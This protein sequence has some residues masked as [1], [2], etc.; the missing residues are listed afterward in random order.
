MVMSVRG[1]EQDKV[2]LRN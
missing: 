2:K 1:N